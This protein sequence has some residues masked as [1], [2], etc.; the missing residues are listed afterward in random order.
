MDFKPTA[1]HQPPDGLT[2]GPPQGSTPAKSGKWDSL[3]QPGL[4]VIRCW[5]FLGREYDQKQG[6]C[7]ARGRCRIADQEKA[8]SR[9]FIHPAGMYAAIDF[10][11][12]GYYTLIDHLR[13]Y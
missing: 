10:R 1:T 5:F 6:I 8:Q 13:L 4:N 2:P 3:S 7:Q 9:L 11:G 12:S